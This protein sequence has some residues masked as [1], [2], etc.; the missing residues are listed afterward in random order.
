MKKPI[1]IFFTWTI[2]GTHLPGSDKWWSSHD[3]RSIPPMPKLERWNKDRLKHPVWTLNG[4]ERITVENTVFKHCDLRTWKLWKVNART[5]H[6]HAV[7]T[8]DAVKPEIIRDQ[9]K[10]YCT[11]DLRCEYPRW[12]DRPVWTKGGDCTFVDTEL[13]LENVIEYVANGQ[14]INEPK[15]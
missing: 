12:I 2:Y 5:S 10:A 1:A 15:Y 6:V 14:D 7:I 11:R 3:K 4:S 9:L 13:E 8:A